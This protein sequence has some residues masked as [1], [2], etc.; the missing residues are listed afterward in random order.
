MQD[1]FHT[2]HT[3]LQ[4]E[5]SYKTY[6]TFF[7]QDIQDIWKK[8]KYLKW[9]VNKGL[10]FGD[11]SDQHDINIIYQ[12]LFSKSHSVVFTQFLR[13]ISN[14]LALSMCLEHNPCDFHTSHVSCFLATAIWCSLFLWKLNITTVISSCCW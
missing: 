1:F 2:R 5:F 4:T 3:R 6:K 13:D 8:K 14:K 12:L 7:I 10:T 9:F 11:L